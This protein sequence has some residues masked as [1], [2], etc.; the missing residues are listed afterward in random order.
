LTIII[1]SVIITVIKH[2]SLNKVQEIIM[3]DVKKTEEVDRIYSDN[4]VSRN[5]KGTGKEKI[6][7]LNAERGR[8]LDEIE[9]YFEYHPG[10]KDASIILLNEIDVGMAR[11][12][13]R[14]NAK[15]FGER[16]SR[17]RH[18]FCFCSP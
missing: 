7:F 4:S 18:S 14:N 11:S 13:N 17:K 10:L 1:I 6:V 16:L 2:R 8:Y 15:E 9:A 5:F 12:G 3:A